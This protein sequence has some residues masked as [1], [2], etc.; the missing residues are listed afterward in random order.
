M[1]KLNVLLLHCCRR[2]SSCKCSSCR[3]N[4]S[5]C[6]P[7]TNARVYWYWRNRLHAVA[8]LRHRAQSPPRNLLPCS[9]ANQH[10]IST[11]ELFLD[12]VSGSCV[13]L[14]LDSVLNVWWCCFIKHWT[15]L[16]FV[17][18]NWPQSSEMWM[19]WWFTNIVLL[20][21]LLC[22][23]PSWHHVQAYWLTKRPAGSAVAGKTGATL[24][25][26]CRH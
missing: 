6:C 21:Q 10:C 15:V 13:G 2:P 22:L 26:T 4:R 8:T 25:P 7:K 11:Q 24:G 16:V 19:I 14:R 3:T 5:L 17:F 9:S 18:N 12:F 20:R 1:G 23:P